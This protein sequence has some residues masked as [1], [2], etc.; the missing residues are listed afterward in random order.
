MDEKTELFDFFF[1][2]ERL[3]YLGKKN[4]INECRDRWTNGCG[5][6]VTPGTYAPYDVKR[7]I[8]DC[9]AASKPLDF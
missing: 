3:Q 4:N 8:Y 5:H 1:R 7:G 2:N 9:N 6:N